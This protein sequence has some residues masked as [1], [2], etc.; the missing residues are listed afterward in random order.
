MLA[1]TGSGDNTNSALAA[2]TF[3]TKGRITL[4]QAGLL[5]S[6]DDGTASTGD[7]TMGG[8]A[9]SAGVVQLN[10]AIDIN[11]TGTD[12]SIK[13]FDGNTLRVTLGKLT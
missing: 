7:S 9:T 1:A 2:G 12:N 11:A 13:I 6:D 5:I 4:L 8:L 10:N 3:I